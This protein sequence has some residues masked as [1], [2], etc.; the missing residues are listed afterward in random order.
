[1]TGIIET[2]APGK[3]VLIGEYAVLEGA[4]AIAVAV[5][6]RA[7][8]SLRSR[9]SDECTL[10]ISNDK[11]RFTFHW[12]PRGGIDWTEP[13]VGDRG[14][15]LE[16]TVATLAESGLM[17][18]DLPGIELHINSESFYSGADDGTPLKLGLGSSAA[19][20]VAVTGALLRLFPDEQVAK[21]DLLEICLR[22]H[23]RF[24]GQLG[25]GIDV[26]SALFGGVIALEPKPGPIP[27]VTPLT[28]PDGLFALPV[29][30]GV[31]ASTISMLGSAKAFRAKSPDRHQLHMNALQD[32]AITALAAWRAND[33]VRLLAMIKK[34]SRELE[35]YDND[36]MIGIFSPPH[37]SLQQLVTARGAV[38][39]PT[40]A[41]GGDCGMAF[42]DNAE[43]I[44]QLKSELQSQGFMFT[45]AE[46]G[47]DGF[48]ATAS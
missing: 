18:N 24:Q 37:R 1:M 25:S 17:L 31:P 44:A 46:L 4:P 19:V 26:A 8:V 45:D 30:T 41:G 2:D 38:Y 29:W 32:I 21:L 47:A 11:S 23:R 42:A 7:R 20:S 9:D 35:N 3:L 36:S 28:W 39:K 13:D 15:L 34:Y 27:S 14:T 22:G 5:D 6:T 48:C 43:T 10:I 12:T 33:S 16:A 40:G